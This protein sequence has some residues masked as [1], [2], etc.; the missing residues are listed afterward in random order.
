M[1]EFLDGNPEDG[2]FNQ[3]WY[4]KYTIEQMVADIA[5]HG[6]DCK[7][8]YLSTPSI[9]FST[10]I[11][12]QMNSKCFEFDKKWGSDQGFVFYD[13]NK[14]EDIPQDLHGTF[15]LVVVDPP[16]IVREVWEK[17]AKACKI[18][19]KTGDDENGLPKGKMILT[20]VHENHA[21]LQ[22][23]L[24][25]NGSEVEVPSEVPGSIIMTAFL[26]VVTNLVYQYN[27]YTNYP[28]EIFSKKN[29]EVPDFD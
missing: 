18:L 19:L 28:S 17:Y 20:T 16:F 10:P 9:Y 29:P 21:M 11:Q 14:P 8:A 25:K 15:D 6:P 1:E 24:G 13:Y 27:L 22:E 12:H 5:S 3:Y 26:P 4:S 7:A 2:D 23:I